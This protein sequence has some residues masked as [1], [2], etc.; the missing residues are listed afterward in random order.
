MAGDLLSTSKF[1]KALSWEKNF[2]VSKKTACQ[3]LWQ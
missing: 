1:L 3:V 2:S